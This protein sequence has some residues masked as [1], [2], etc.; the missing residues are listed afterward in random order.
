MTKPSPSRSSSGSSCGG[1]RKIAPRKKRNCAARLQAEDK[2]AGAAL[3]SGDP[4]R[5]EALGR[6]WMRHMRCGEWSAAWQ[7]SDEVL[8]AHR[9][10][11]C[12]SLPRHLQ[13]IWNGE[14][15]DGKRVLIR[16]YH[17]LGDTIQF[18]RYASLVRQRAKHSAVWAQPSLLP[19]LR[20]VDGID[21]LLPLHDG[22]PA[23]DFEADV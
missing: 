5:A 10:Q 8:R 23:A 20:T 12:A 16:C 9:N 1:C 14:P 15:L 13:W 19:L 2:A 22:T 7:V 18:I 11:S 21:E 17:G 6:A 3:A 4:R